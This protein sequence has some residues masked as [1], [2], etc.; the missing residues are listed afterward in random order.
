MSEM[1]CNDFVKSMAAAGF[2]FSYIATNGEITVRG[3]KN[4][5]VD[6]PPVVSKPVSQSRQEIRDMFKRTAM[7]HPNGK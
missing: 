6:R 2:S 1:S 3:E 5:G 4:T 7:E